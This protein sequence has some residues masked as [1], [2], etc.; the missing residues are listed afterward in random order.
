MTAELIVS[1][2]KI[3]GFRCIAILTLPDEDRVNLTVVNDVKPVVSP[4][5][6]PPG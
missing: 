4:S 3:D 5:I 6:N 1:I 2:S